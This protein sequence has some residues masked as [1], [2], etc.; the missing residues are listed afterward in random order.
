MEPFAPQEA[1]GRGD[2]LGGLTQSIQQREGA[3]GRS[4]RMGRPGGRLEVVDG[5]V[6]LRT[7]GVGEVHGVFIVSN[8]GGGGYA[9]EFV[10]RPHKESRAQSSKRSCREW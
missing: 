9:H 3:R 4:E 6:G 1:L 7:F 2:G 5:E 8:Y 10:Q